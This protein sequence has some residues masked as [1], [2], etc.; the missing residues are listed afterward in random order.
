MAST[1]ERFVEEEEEEE[2]EE[3]APKDFLWFLFRL[4]TSPECRTFQLRCRHRYP[5]CKLSSKPSRSRYSSWMVVDVPVAVQRQVPEMVADS[6]GNCGRLR[7]C[8]S[9]VWSNS[10]TRL[11]T[12]LL[13][14]NDRCR[15]LCF[16]KVFD[17]PVMPVETAQVGLL[18]AG[19]RQGVDVAVSMQR[20][21]SS[22]PHRQLRFL[23]PV[24]RHGRDELRW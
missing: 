23:S 4:W 6:A 18:D 9:R 12:G 15:K 21:G 13:L 7:S 1:E 10:V 2:E 19:H 14:F 20:Q 17:V 11:L 8:S 16:D 3:E 22:C 24:H 5:Q